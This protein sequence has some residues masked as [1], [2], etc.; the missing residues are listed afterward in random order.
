MN[1]VFTRQSGP[2]LPGLDR[3]IA[4]G[5]AVVALCA[6]ALVL[7]LDPGLVRFAEVAVADVGRIVAP[8]LLLALFLERAIEVVVGAWR[9]GDRQS[10]E[11]A[12]AAPELDLEERQGRR[13]ILLAH[14]DTTRCI[15]LLASLT[16]GVLLSALGVRVLEQLVD[17]DMLAA[18]AEW[19]QRSFAVLDVLITG[20]LLAGGA[21]GLHKVV[22]TFTTFMEQSAERIRA[23]G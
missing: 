16:A 1:Q 3:R 2:G 23:A 17:A 22:A 13:N 6:G 8:L 5:Y 20:A 12:C 11:L 10:L 7:A 4:M 19:Q 9:E 18:L 21:D 14:R 15:A